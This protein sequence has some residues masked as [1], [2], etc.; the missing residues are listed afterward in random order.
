MVIMFIGKYLLW[1]KQKI[2]KFSVNHRKYAKISMSR[3]T[4]NRVS[5]SLIAHNSLITPWNTM[6]FCIYMTL[7]V[8]NMYQKYDK[9]F[10]NTF[11]VIGILT[12][13][14]MC[15]VFAVFSK[16]YNFS[17]FQAYILKY[18]W[19]TIII[20]LGFVGVFSSNVKTAIKLSLSMIFQ[21]IFIE[22][23]SGQKCP[24]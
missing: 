14:G 1:L 10:S 13:K 2:F 8:V 15:H 17:N 4:K 9:C 7:N 23:E 11:F 16:K 20:T 18:T 12:S 22:T 3:V 21:L 5:Q 19:V 24:I 6:K